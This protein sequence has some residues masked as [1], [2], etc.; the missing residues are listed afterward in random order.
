MSEGE[1]DNEQVSEVDDT[2]L[3]QLDANELRGFLEKE[4]VQVIGKESAPLVSNSKKFAASCLFDDDVGVVLAR[5]C[6]LAAQ[7]TKNIPRAPETDSHSDHGKGINDN[8][9]SVH[10]ES[11]QGFAVKATKQSKKTRRREQQFHDETVHVQAHHAPKDANSIGNHTG[12]PSTKPP[13]AIAKSFPGKKVTL[14]AQHPLVIRICHIGIRRAEQTLVTSNAWPECKRH[15]CPDYHQEIMSYAAEKVAK[16]DARALDVVAELKNEESKF[17]MIIGN[18]VSWV[19]D[20]KKIYQ[21]DS[22]KQL[23]RNAF[24]KTDTDFGYKYS[25]YYTSTHATRKENEITMPL[26][27]LAATGLYSAISSWESGACIKESFDAEKNK[28]TYNCHIGY[29]EGMKRDNPG[30][31]HKIMLDLLAYATYVLFMFS[32]MA[33][34]ITSFRISQPKAMASAPVGSALAVADFADYSE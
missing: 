1:E 24:F 12:A 5:H 19:I 8:E 6:K 18:L 9:D 7:A 4:M 11:P 27:A 16:S 21:S 31:Y 34:L 22:F 32:F 14:R 33:L 28:P 23:L 10:E 15:G 26:V 30:A 3:R 25:K 20:R 17:A 29:L 2:D 13:W